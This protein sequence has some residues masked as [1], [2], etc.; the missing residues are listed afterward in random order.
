[1]ISSFLP[2]LSKKQQALAQTGRLSLHSDLLYQL[3]NIS[4]AYEDHYVLSDIN[5]T[6][7]K[8]EI[9]FIT[10]PSGAGKTTLLR[11]LS[12]DLR[13]YRGKMNSQIYHSE[14]FV[15]QIFQDL[16]LFSDK[17]CYENLLVSYDSHSYDAFNSFKADLYDLAA[18]LGI[19]DRL[20]LKISNCN[21][22]LKQKV[23]ILRALLSR[24]DVLIADEPSSALDWDNTRKI[25]ELLQLYNVKR[26]L[27][28]IWATHNRE[29]A[30]RFT[31]RGLHLER[32]KMIHKGHACFI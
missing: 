15:A 5:F 22:G 23:A 8:G 29:L 16:K 9:L 11:I 2:F 20:H 18:L 12:G 27:S 14:V 13:D 31:G 19:K 7:R 1:M 25:F 6:V 17:T 30:Q 24:P 21:G 26:G 28:V 10:G 3:E 4:Y 32:G